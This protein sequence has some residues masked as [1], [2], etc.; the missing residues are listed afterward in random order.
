M[1][2]YNGITQK[3]PVEV[4][5]NLRRGYG[6]M[7]EHVLDSPQVGASFNQVCGKRMPERMRPNSL[8]QAGFFGKPFNDQKDHLP[9]QLAAPA[10]QKQ[11]V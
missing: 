5:V 4:C 9:A 2:L 7:A 10:V 6:F 1:K 3:F 11:D 8:F